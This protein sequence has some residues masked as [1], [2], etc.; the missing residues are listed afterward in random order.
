MD[1]QKTC[2]SCR[3]SQFFAANRLN[4]ISSVRRHTLQFALLWTK[5]QNSQ[6]IFYPHERRRR[7]SENNR[8]LY[9]NPNH[10][11]IIISIPLA[12][13]Y[14]YC[15]L[16]FLLIYRSLKHGKTTL[17]Q[18]HEKKMPPS[19]IPLESNKSPIPNESYRYNIINC[20]PL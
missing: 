10:C 19:Q 18:Y 7:S 20:P 8:L 9:N 5:N 1:V 14:R 12:T 16:I 3:N 17:Q 2:Y 13:L 6:I 11:I 4:N 15:I